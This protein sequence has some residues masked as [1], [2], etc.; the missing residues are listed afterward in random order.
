M[1]ILNSYES[2]ES[3]KLGIMRDKK[4]RP[5]DVAVP[6]DH[7]GSLFAPLPVKPARVV[8]PPKPVPE[9]TST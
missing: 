8:L 2:G 5:L 7:H 6:A 3:L 1:R 9:I 4:K